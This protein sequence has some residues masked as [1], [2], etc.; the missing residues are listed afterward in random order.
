[1]SDTL[2]AVIGIIIP[3]LGTTLGAAMVFF[4]KGE[5]R[6]KL[7]KALLGFASGVMIAA[8]VWSL[9][10]PAIEMTEARGGTAWLPA[11]LGF[12]MGIGFLLALDSLIPHLHLNSETP[13]G[14]PTRLKKSLML[15][16]RRYAAQ[17]FP[18]HGCGRGS[19]GCCPAGR[20]YHSRR[21]ALAIACHSNFPGGASSPCPSCEPGLSS[22]KL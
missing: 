18:R 11:A 6:P 8:S 14:V 9:L 22:E 7:Q 10:I 2:K 4:M 12:L 17:H 13:E 3:L 21:L 19:G 20:L 16:R 5:M 15:V 1:M